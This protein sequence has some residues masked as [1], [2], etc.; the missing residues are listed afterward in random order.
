MN[1]ILL[2]EDD[3]ILRK[4]IDFFLKSKGYTV[5]NAENGKEAMNIID[6][7]SFDLIITDL[8]LPFVNGFE[9]IQYM[10]KVIHSA[11]P[12][13]VLTSHGVESTE[14]ESF[15][16]GASEFISK[17]FSPSVLNARVNKLLRA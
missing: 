3:N 7:Q 10:R 11:L 5:I 16:L 2:I 6:N 8:N 17:P 4:S 12:I 14:L 9:L 13:I 15:E 1:T